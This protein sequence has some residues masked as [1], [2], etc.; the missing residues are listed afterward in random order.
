M[1]HPPPALV[2]IST[3]T[4]ESKQSQSEELQQSTR[5][6]EGE[7]GIDRI[8]GL[9]DGILGD[10]I[11]LLPTKDGACTQILASRWRNLW[12]SAPL[13]LDH[14]G[15]PANEEVQ[16]S[17]ISHITA[18]HNGPIRCL[19]LPVLHL[20]HHRKTLN[21]WLLSPALNN[22]QDLEFEATGMIHT[23]WLLPL[24]SCHV[25]KSSH[26]LRIATISECHMPDLIEVCHFPH[27][28]QL[29]LEGVMI[30]DYALNNLVVGCLILESLLLKQCFGFNSIQI[31]STSLKS[32]GLSATSRTNI[33]I[34]DAPLLE[35]FLILEHLL[36]IHFHVI[37]VSAP[38]L[39]TFGCISDID[40]YNQLVF[41]TTI[42]QVT[43]RA[44]QLRLIVPWPIPIPWLTPFHSMADPG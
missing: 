14:N 42:M 43:S 36:G 9:P 40:S 1:Q 34:E 20:N 39:E 29:G 16:A 17:L 31:N 5:D 8:S 10:I 4:D 23:S 24:I 19:S 33:I 44:P 41:G 7:E 26:T 2:L 38:K 25:F 21:T 3:P 32:I 37:V 27:L 11:S 13:N 35:R 22:L 18:N 28:K 30:S 6:S 15:L 12:P